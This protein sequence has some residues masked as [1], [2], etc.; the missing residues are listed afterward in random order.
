MSGYYQVHIHSWEN[1]ADHYQTHIVD[2]FNPTDVRFYVALGKNFNSKNNRT[3]KGL[4][5]GGVDSETLVALFDEL[6]AEY[7]PGMTRG[8]IAA[9][10]PEEE[11]DVDDKAFF[12][13]DQLVELVLGNAD[14]FYMGEYEHF[15]RVVDGIKVFWVPE[16]LVEVTED[17]V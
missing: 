15:C 12:Y 11:L 7:G 6:L 17:F 14:E 10:T 5:N 13:H 8:V 16:S 4:G 3:D 9:W 1:D 2:A